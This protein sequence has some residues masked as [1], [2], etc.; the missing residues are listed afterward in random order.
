MGRRAG[1]AGGV[2]GGVPSRAVT[3]S[4]YSQPSQARRDHSKALCK[5]CV[6]YQVSSGMYDLSMLYRM[7]V[8]TVICMY[9][10]C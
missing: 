1:G 9:I 10:H 6:E 3:P 5:L 8:H 7:Y 2:R 4:N